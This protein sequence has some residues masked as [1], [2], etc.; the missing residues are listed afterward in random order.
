MKIL[1]SPAK[2]QQFPDGK[3]KGIHGTTPLYDNDIKI[4]WK[5]L[6][7]F[8]VAELEALYKINKDK[9]EHLYAAYHPIKTKRRPALLA[10]T[11]IVYKSMDLDTWN[12]ADYAYAQQHTY[13]CSALYGVLRPLDLI[14]EYRLDMSHKIFGTKE[15]MSDIWEE[16]WVKR[17]K[18]IDVLI[19]LTSKEFS[20]L[21]N[22][23]NMI[24]IEFFDEKDGELKKLNTYVKIARGKMYK[25]IVK[26]KIED[27]EAI[28]QIVVDNYVYDAE[29]SSDKVW[30]FVKK[31]QGKKEI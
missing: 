8:S 17:F 23:P 9:A 14:Q 7:R 31:E 18:K 30:I 21:I 6:K 5:R 4:F 12:K 29:L 25:E 19:N 2:T 16:H 13:I 15:K 10:Y 1:L 11:G 22:H 20:S 24:T 3:L 28:K 27:V 26:H